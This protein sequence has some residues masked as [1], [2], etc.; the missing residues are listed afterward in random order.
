MTTV[1]QIAESMQRVLADYAEEAARFTGFV[2]RA[3]KLSGS[4]FVQSLVFGWLGNPQS[5]LSGLTQTAAA[6]GVEISNQGL[7]QRFNERA[8]LFME[9]MLSAVVTEVVSADP[10]AIPLFERFGAVVLQDS[11]VIVL[12]GELRNEWLGVGGGHGQGVA[13]LK[14]QIRLDLSTGG[15][16]GPLLE[17]GRSQDKGA[18]IQSE[19]LPVG[20]LRIA[21]LGYF[22]LEVL[23]DIDEEGCFY[24]TRLQIQTAV[25]DEQGKELD[26]LALLRKAG[27]AG[28][29]KRILLGKSRRLRARLMAM[30]VPL[31]VA[32]E[33]RRRMREGA[34]HRG[35]GISQ[36]ALDL[37]GWTF[38]VTNVMED[39]LSVEEALALMR[40]RWQIEL[41][42]KLWKHQGQVDEWR[43]KRPWRILCETYAKLIAMVIQHWLILVSI[44]RYPDRSLGKAAQTVR[45]FAM[46]LASAM[47]RAKE[48]VT[49]IEQIRRCLSLGCRMN[50]RKQRPNTY[51]LL[52]APQPH[53]V[54][55]LT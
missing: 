8:V 20:A 30:P 9:E 32:N 37:A 22:S 21:D 18:D 13:A 16:L 4:G 41:L 55:S 28:V 24:L 35:Q 40:A 44:W 53:K 46:M 52:L 34:K 49:T 51:Q 43:S 25:L 42:F 12:P 19:P 14:L 10:V 3:S 33:R 54:C 27:P 23:R 47:A 17:D 38:L 2:Q 7:D 15:L 31:E 26:L 11:S 45:H 1:P 50:R 6:T 29:D 48:L 39:R 5:S 36:R